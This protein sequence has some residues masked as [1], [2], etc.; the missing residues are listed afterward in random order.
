M[1]FDGE[2]LR[3]KMLVKEME[4]KKLP[5]PLYTIS[6]VAIKKPSSLRGEFSLEGADGPTPPEGYVRRF[7][8]MIAEVKC[9]MQG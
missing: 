8:A 4:D 6:T 7:T 2:V 5:N 1:P 3:V 9:G